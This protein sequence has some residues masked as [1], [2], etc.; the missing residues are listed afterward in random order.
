MTAMN[1]TMYTEGI[2]IDVCLFLQANIIK[3]MEVRVIMIFQ[4]III[5]QL[6]CF[7]FLYTLR[8]IPSV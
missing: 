5:Y 7:F 3:H 6:Q 2:Q 4:P 8:Y 1:T